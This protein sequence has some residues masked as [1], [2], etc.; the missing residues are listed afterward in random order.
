MFTFFSRQARARKKQAE[1][2]YQAIAGQARKAEFY[3]DFGVPDTFDGRFEMLCLHGWLVMRKLKAAGDEKLSQAL[4]DHMFKAMDET[5]REIGVGDLSV[6]KHMRRMM[7]GFNGRAN[8]YEE[9]LEDQAAMKESLR[10][11]VYGTLEETEEDKV[12]ALAAYVM[13]A[14]RAPLQDKQEDTHAAQAG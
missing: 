13:E 8:S 3:A 9:V 12:A 4:F 14:A 11:N 5:I 1:L 7:T 2:L 10:R 6:P